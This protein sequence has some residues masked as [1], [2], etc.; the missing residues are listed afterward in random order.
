MNIRH[1]I[2]SLMVFTIVLSCASSIAFGQ[3]AQNSFRTTLVITGD[4]PIPPT[5]TTTPPTT[6]GGSRSGSYLGSP[7]NVTNFKA[8]P[9]ED[10]I[11]LSWTMP[12]GFDILG[13]R[14]VRSDKF[15]PRDPSEG[16]VIVE[17]NVSSFDDAEVEIGKEYFYTIFTKDFRGRYSSGAVANARLPIPG[18]AVPPKYIPFIDVPMATGVSPIISG[19]TLRDFDFIQDGRILPNDGETIAID[20][21]KNLTVRL[22]YSKIS[23]S[24]KTIALTLTDPGDSTK[25]FSF[26][27]RVNESETAFEST[28]GPLGRSGRYGLFVSVLDYKNQGLKQLQ[29]NLQAFVLGAVQNAFHGTDIFGQWN[30]WLLFL[31]LLIILA[32]TIYIMTKRHER[33]SFSYTS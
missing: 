1:L 12:V 2:I 19:L 16:E 4:T 21:T 18:I 33:K 23:E 29:G 14:L 26:L 22:D 17:G 31:L 13:I 3:S 7:V 27:L 11:S 9:D 6:G 24:L 20:G 8:I 32:V 5:P 25:V 15:F 10:S 28:I 30:L